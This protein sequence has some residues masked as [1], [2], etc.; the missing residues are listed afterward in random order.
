MFLTNILPSFAIDPT[1]ALHSLTIFC[2]RN[3]L[4]RPS[5]CNKYKT[6]L[7][8]DGGGMKGMITTMVLQAISTS[9]KEFYL[10]NPW[11]LKD[12][13]MYY[14]LVTYLDFD[15]NLSDHFDI[16][17]GISA[18]SW[19]ATYLATNGGTIPVPK[20]DKNI[21]FKA[22]GRSQE[23]FNLKHIRRKFG[24]I[25]AGNP[26]GL[27][28]FFL[29]YGSYIYPPQFVPFFFQ[30]RLFALPKPKFDQLTVPAYT[31][32]G[33]EWV[34]GKFLGD[35]ALNQ[36]STSLIIAAFDLNQRAAI[37]FVANM[38]NGKNETHTNV[39]W[40]TS[41]PK[42]ETPDPD[43]DIKGSV[44]SLP[45]LNYHLRDLTRASSAF[46]MIHGSKLVKPLEDIRH[47]FDLIDGAM[48]GNNPTLQSIVWI[49]E[50]LNCTFS[51]IASISIG[52]GTVTG[53]YEEAG[54][55]GLLKWLAPIISLL[56]DSSTEFI[57]S[58]IDFLYYG[59]LGDITLPNQYL[60]I[61]VEGEATSAVGRALGSIDRVLD[62]P[63]LKKIGTG[64]GIEYKSNI[65]AFVKEFIF[66]GNKEKC[67]PWYQNKTV[68]KSYGLKQNEGHG[69]AG[70]AHQFAK[71]APWF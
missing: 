35:I 48:V 65:D 9:I 19:M 16:I 43:S 57:Q 34:L 25:R 32:H 20:G 38:Y 51:D 10:T 71:F 62:L 33:L 45:K 61:Q 40:T 53:N 7:A 70:V 29:E 12:E 68:G 30:P 36:V 52:T 67:T 15:I 50:N 54:T 60:R 37:Q 39:V 14:R 31:P 13:E 58:N 44:R 41:R 46:P 59:T 66:V 4:K 47:E 55:G 1:C 8:L 2:S 22:V 6:L 21:K 69:E 11:V 56:L 17:A 28:V 26:K 49:I 23:I 24:N 27:E 42:S 18:G 5:E 64:L 3:I 63:M